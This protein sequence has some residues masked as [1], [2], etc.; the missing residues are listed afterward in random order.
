M[1]I[2][3]AGGTGFLGSP[4]AEVYAEEGH[5]VRVLTRRLPVGEARHESGTGMPG[6]TSVGWKPDGREDAA[7]SATLTALVDDADGLINLAG[8]SIGDKRWT[9]QRKAELRDSRIHPTRALISAIGAAPKPPRVLVS[10]SGVGYYGASG[11]EPKTED[12][13][14]GRDFLARM[15]EDWEAEARRAAGAGTRVVLLRTGMVIE[16]SGGALAKMMPAFRFFAGGR[17]GSGRQYVSWIHRLDYLEMVRWIIGTPAVE[18]PVNATAPHP[19]TNR[20]FARALGHGLRRP[21][22]V[23]AP[24]FALKILLGEM[25]DSLVLTG[26]RV[27]PARA[28]AHGYH[29]RYPEI[30][31]AMRGIF[32]AEG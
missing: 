30:D 9:A 25:A 27:I 11:D 7:A 21:S 8:E 28:Q 23:P 6:V 22:I 15:S 12:S 29:F 17:M 14:A 1:K 20:E 26:Q 5:D 10:A 16:R 13:P 4:L 31:I 19:V 18:G 24:S 2:V 3:I 32:N